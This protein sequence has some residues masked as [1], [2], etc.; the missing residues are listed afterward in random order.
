VE[1]TCIKLSLVLH[2]L[3]SHELPI[4]IV[5]IF[6]I[7]HVVD[8]MLLRWFMRCKDVYVLNV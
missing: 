6:C 5:T 4:M 3:E 7:T 1:V 2:R 8:L